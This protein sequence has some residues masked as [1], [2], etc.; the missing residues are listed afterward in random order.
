MHEI[1]SQL[2]SNI[3]DT[4]WLEVIAVIFGILSVWFARK[5]NIWVYPT[6]IVNVLVYVYLCFFAGLYADMAINAFYFVMS[7]FGWY[8]WS[9]RDEN[10]HHVPI[11]SLSIKQWLFYVLLIAVAF[12]I[13]Y[14]VLSNFTDSTVPV[15]DSFTTSLFIAGMWLMAI[16]KIENWLLWILGDVLVIPMFAIKGLAF[17]SVQYIVFLVLAIMAYIEWRKRLKLKEIL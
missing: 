13:I 8:N 16:K 17:T 5:E 12:G 9:R 11:T 10:S 4:S 6:G 14:Y 7:V 1:L 3:L 15:F 2:Y